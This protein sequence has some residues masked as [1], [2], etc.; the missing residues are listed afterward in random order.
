MVHPFPVDSGWDIL[1][2]V[3]DV[4]IF[5]MIFGVAFLAGSVVRRRVG[6]ADGDVIGVV[7][8][9]GL[10]SVRELPVPSGVV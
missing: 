4:L 2:P 9:S 6:H 1:P 7:S 8:T 3:S 10:M 5:A